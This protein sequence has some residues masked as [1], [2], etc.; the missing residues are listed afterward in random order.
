MV[1]DHLAG[2]D[3]L[4][5]E[6]TLQDASEPYLFHMSARQAGELATAAG[7]RR[8]LLTHIPPSVD[9]AISLVEAADSYTG[10]LGL[11]TAGDTY[12]IEAASDQQKDA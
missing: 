9:P 11:A 6:A 8:L 7:A 5:A 2:V 1:A 12:I 4:L 3:V 10:R